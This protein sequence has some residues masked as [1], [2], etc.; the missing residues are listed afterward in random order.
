MAQ[1]QVEVQGGRAVRHGTQLGRGRGPILGMDEVDDLTPDH[2]ALGPTERRRPSRVDGKSGGIGLRHQHE[3][4]RQPP[5][6]VTLLR[7]FGH[8][9]LERLVEHL[10]RQQR[11]P[12]ARAMARLAPTRASSSRAENGLTR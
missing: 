6:P 1:A 7:A 2:L 5:D 9:R 10:Q 4:A 8:A 11:L 3:L 12:P